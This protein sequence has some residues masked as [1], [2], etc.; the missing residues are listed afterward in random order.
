[1]LLIGV[2]MYSAVVHPFP[3]GFESNSQAIEHHIQNYPV[4]VLATIIPLWG[5][6][7]YTGTWVAIKLGTWGSGY[8]IAVLMVI[9]LLCCL[10]MFPYPWWFRLLQPL[11][12]M[13]AIFIAIGTPRGRQGTFLD[14]L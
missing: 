7:A 1:M 8:A 11:A 4:W 3:P 5:L 13:V 9:A 2:E 6:I 12:V 14:W 10:T